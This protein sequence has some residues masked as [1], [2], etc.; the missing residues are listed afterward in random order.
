MKKPR[1][2]TLKKRAELIDLIIDHYNHVRKRK[3]FPKKIVEDVVRLMF[4]ISNFEGRG[5]F[6]EVHAIRSKAYRRVLKISN[7]RSTRRDWK[8]YQRLPANIRNRYFAKI[9]WNT[10]YCQLQK[11][12]RKA[13]I[14]KAELMKLKLIGKKYG[15]T[16]IRPQNVRKVDGRFK[17][18]DASPALASR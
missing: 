14:P 13:K 8:A 18:V 12:G 7:G 17:I 16:D 9:Y 5:A 1:H 3:N 15:L 10:K 11:F 6:K 4:P 2:A